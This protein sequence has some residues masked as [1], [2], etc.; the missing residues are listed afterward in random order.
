MD[1]LIALNAVA[2]IPTQPLHPLN[3]LTADI[4]H[5]VEVIRMTTTRYGRRAV[6]HI[7]D[8][9]YFLPARVGLNLD[10]NPQR[11]VAL[12][13]LAREGKLQMTYLGRA[14]NNVTF[15]LR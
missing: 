4:L 9:Q 8:A 10:Q 2:N 3:T 13:R 15:H 12:Q 6:I 1:H 11:V 14:V 7:A 5:D